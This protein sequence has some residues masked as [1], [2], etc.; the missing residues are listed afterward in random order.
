MD[1]LGNDRKLKVAIVHDWLV[2]Y[3]GAEKVL[4]QILH[5]YPDAD[6]FSTVDHLPDE[7]RWYIMHKKV[8]TTFI[9]KLPFSRKHYRNY[10][11]LM[12]FA[13][14]Q[15]NVSGYDL[16][17]SSSYAVAKGVIT[18]SNQ[19]HVCYCHSPVRYAWDLYHQYLDESGLRR[20]IKGFF[21]KMILHYLRI[22]D[23][24]T[25]SR[26]DLF[27]ANSAY[28]GRRIRKV[29]GRASQVVYPP[30]DINSFA[31]CTEKGTAYVVASRL[32]PYK[33]IDLIARAFSLMPDKELVIIGEGPDFK[34]VKAVAGPN[35]RVAGYLPYTEL[36]SY[37]SRAKAFIIAADEDFGIT[38][39]E[40]QATGTPVIAYG[41]GGVTETVVDGVTG[42]LFHQQEVEAI[43]EAV[44]RFEQQYDR[45]NSAAI[46]R[47]AERFGIDTFRKEFYHAV[48]GALL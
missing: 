30:V 13:I 21:A 4:E 6:I 47:N 34:K 28:V 46:R 19:V 42:V 35:V 45:F 43:V 29:Y 5:L 18:H 10:L 7:L 15:L 26:V 41:R 3:S 2:N 8:H 32:V 22:W 17:I 1:S 39:V 9:Q 31:L 20:G 37:V 38:S 24:T 14:E 36:I 48:N 27:L 12:P 44:E 33:K 11:P 25:A 16:V 40:A 23:Y